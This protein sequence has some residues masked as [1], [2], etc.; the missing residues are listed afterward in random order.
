MRAATCA[1]VVG[2]LLFGCNGQALDALD[3]ASISRN[4][5]LAGR[6][7]PAAVHGRSLTLAGFVDARNLYGDDA[8]RRV[9]GDRWSGPGPG[10]G[11]WRFDLL[12]RPGDAA[13]VA[14]QV[15]AG[16]DRDGLLRAFVADAE[17]GRPT[18]VRVTGHVRTFA[19]PTN[20]GRRVGLA[21]TAASANAVVI[22]R[23]PP[24]R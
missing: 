17:A 14:V 22:E 5:F 18:R 3:L 2:L 19:A 15:G 21:V 13:G 9:L 7:D 20:L 1:A 23:D 16:G 12:A 6:L 24:S 10:A 11:A 8:A 4:G